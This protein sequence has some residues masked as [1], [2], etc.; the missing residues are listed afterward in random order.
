ME[1]TEG[2]NIHLIMVDSHCSMT[3]TNTTLHSNFP[4][5]TK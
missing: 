1:A 5:I 2:G 3:E 4:L